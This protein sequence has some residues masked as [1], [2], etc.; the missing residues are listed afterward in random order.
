MT[1]INTNV[2]SLVA[3]NTLSRSNADLNQALRYHFVKD[4]L[5]FTDGNKRIAAWLFIWYLNMNEYLYTKSG[6]QKIANNALATITL[7]IALSKPE[8]RDLMIRVVINAI[9][10]LKEYLE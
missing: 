10:K 1:R 9:N 2:S 5:I 6:Q 4:Y 3:Q 7:M 8:E